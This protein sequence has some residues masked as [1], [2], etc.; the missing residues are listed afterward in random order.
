[1]GETNQNLWMFFVFPLYNLKSDPK[2]LSNATFRKRIIPE[3]N[4]C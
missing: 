3:K 2:K 4:F 1:M